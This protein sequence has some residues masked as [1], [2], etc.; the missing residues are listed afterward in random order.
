[1]HTL[2]DRTAGW[3]REGPPPVWQVA[4]SRPKLLDQ[5]RAE[6]RL[7][8][9]SARTEEAYVSWIRRFI[10][11]HDKHHPAAMGGAEVTAFLTHL[12]THARVAASTQN[13]A[14]SGLLFLYREVLGGDLPWLDDMVRAPR[15]VRLP[16]VLDRDEVAAVIGCLRGTSWLMAT[17]LY[18][19]GLRLMECV[20]L[21]AKDAD[22]G[23]SQIVVREGKGDKD[24]VTLLPAAVREPLAEQLAWARRRHAADIAAG[25]GWV[26]LPAA[27]GRK[28]PNAGREWPWPW[29]FPATRGYVD[30]ETNE[31][32]RHH[33]HETVLQRHVTPDLLT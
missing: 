16:V 23:A 27:L 4:P 33:L 25:A 2:I 28:Y 3:V 18:G 8:H 7:R 9:L 32:R 11:F 14:L 1:M 30:R 21:R 13:Q 26:E 17:L 5:V 20:R 22:F 29:V 6:A 31:R 19:A 15:P 12:A 24:R 10:L